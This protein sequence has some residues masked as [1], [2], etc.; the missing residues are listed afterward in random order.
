MDIKDQWQV[1]S[2]ELSMRLKELGFPQKSLWYWDAHYEEPAIVLGKRE[3]QK[4]H[5]ESVCSAP[6]VAELGIALPNNLKDKKGNSLWLTLTRRPDGVWFI[7]YD[8]TLERDIVNGIFYYRLTANTE[9]EA[10]GLMWEYLKKNG[11]LK[12]G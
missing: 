9:A 3:D 5:P 1:C 4:Y 6:S 11:L 10:R 8:T 12:E 7:W 2:L